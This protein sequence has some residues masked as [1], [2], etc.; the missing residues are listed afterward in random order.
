M[1]IFVEQQNERLKYTFD[2]IFKERDLNYSFSTDAQYFLDFKGPK[3]NYS[4]IAFKNI[5]GCKPS[6]LLFSLGLQQ[7][8]IDQELFH[9]ERCLTINGI[10]DPIASVF[11][12]LTRYEEYNTSL[13]DRHGR[14]QG[15]KSVLYRFGWHENAM[16][17]RWSEDLLSYLTE[18]GDF[19]YKR[20]R[21]LPQI[22][23][24][25]D[26]DKAYAYKHK[27]LF[28]NS[29]SYFKDLYSKNKEQARERKLVL[30]GS[31]KDP[32][33]NYD[34]IYDIHRRGF[35]IKL[36]WML[37][38]YG[39]FDKN[40]SHK[41]KRHIRLIR[42]MNKIASIGI[43]PS[44]KS[45]SNEF[46]IH[47]EIER[48]QEILEKHVR[49]SRQHFLM[50]TFPKTYQTLIE[51]EIEHDYSMGYADIVGFRAGTAREFKWFDVSKNEVTNLRIHPFTYMDG[52]L[53]EYLK[54]SANEAEEKI[55]QL[56]LE[57]K[58]NG[59]D[60]LFL[61]H[62]DTIGDYGHWKG[63]SKVLEFSLRL[64]EIEV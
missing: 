7:Y 8:S 21:H 48:L 14:H 46:F 1:L 27:G 29:L 63:W 23:P 22:V 10:T 41:N 52:T 9:K 54:L 5:L 35:D 59:G 11:Y 60:F 24:T 33:D 6:P 49:I 17:D 42:K 26:I 40:I 51:Q 39:K 44:Y 57:T 47:N 55:A 2:F 61:W 20:K 50:L 45:N 4:P 58:A 64:N 43:H 56:Y 53:N 19:S 12:I 25:F 13:K 37:G 32:F 15:I 18:K 36:F 62:N 30:R 3:F 28:R 16:C 38:N 34:K 31:K